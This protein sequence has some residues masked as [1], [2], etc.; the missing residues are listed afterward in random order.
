M[1]TNQ[2]LIKNNSCKTEGSFNLHLDNDELDDL[3]WQN[4]LP[5]SDEEWDE[6]FGDG[7]IIP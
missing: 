1:N 3:E 6:L 5:I 2:Y 7:V 4:L